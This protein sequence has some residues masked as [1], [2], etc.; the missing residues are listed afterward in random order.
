MSAQLTCDPIVKI[1]LT[2]NEVFDE[3]APGYVLDC[4]V[5]TK[6]L[7]KP[8][9]FEF[10]IRK[11]ELTLE[12]SD[13][14]FELRDKLLAAM[15]EVTLKA[16]YHDMEEDDFK[17]YEVEDF[18]YGYI[19]NIKVLRSNGSPV[20][21]KCV[22]YSP[23]A[24]MKHHPSSIS[25]IDTKLEA[26]VNYVLSI[27]A[28]EKMTHF[29]RKEG[30]YSEPN[31]YL[32]SILEPQ[33]QGE[34]MPYT[35][36]FRE[37]PYNFL[38]RLARR[39]AEFMYYE[40]RKF[41]F[42]KMQELPE[43]VLHNGADLEE[44]T[45]EMNMNDHDGP[46]Y[47]SMDTYNRK[48]I[49]G[50]YQKKNSPDS[51]FSIYEGV[52]FGDGYD[53]MA[54]STY[55]AAS[56]YF[57]DLWTSADELG[58][59][60]LHDKDRKSIGDDHELKNW[61]SRQHEY[62]ERY[63]MS[64]A[65]TCT[66]K[67]A[68]VD[69]KLGSVIK[70]K[71]Q[72]KIDEKEGEWKEHTPL[73]VVELMYYWNSK[74]NLAV[75][76]RFKA[77]PQSA[78]VPPYLERDKDG[79]LVYG[80]FDQYPKSGPQYGVVVDNEDPDHLGRVR[81]ALAWQ[82]L[83]SGLVCN[84]TKTDELFTNK[85]NVTP[86]IWVVSPYQGF[87]HGALAIPEI[88]SQV[89]VGF[90]QNNAE[91]PYVMGSRYFKDTMKPEWTK[92]DQNKV[93]GFRTRSGHTVEF[94][95]ADGNN[96]FNAFNNGGRI[97]IYDAETHAYDILFDT[98][99]KLIRMKSKGNI[100]LYA[101]KDIVMQAGNDIVIT[102]ENDMTEHIGNNLRIDAEK[103]ISQNAGANFNTHSAENTLISADKEIGTVSSEGTYID[104][105]GEFK[106]VVDE[107]LSMFAEKDM[108]LSDSNNIDISAEKTLEIKGKDIVGNAKNEFSEYSSDHNIKAQNGVKI[109]AT[110]SIDLK[111]LTI[112]E[113]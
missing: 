67:S 92:Y 104:V 14:D 88:G 111:A 82:L 86:W 56:D 78:T 13:I 69:L 54:K 38:V 1:T 6:G 41:I 107:E 24:R 62:L 23:D 87:D 55:N 4:F 61:Y 36:Q 15:V 76:N 19:Q 34:I 91:R 109:N 40:N 49:G 2:S 83:H 73:K 108:H 30:T 77:I 44:F 64:D 75:L 48:L 12:P 99:Q 51:S 18:F 93:K 103:D 106:L 98:D 57:G 39:Y 85:D 97:H 101:D 59:T 81:V 112:K 16:R 105:Y 65:L 102:A 31:N 66:G 20:T 95:D 71:D 94:I 10:V 42:G 74:N 5:L 50:C 32:E 84:S 47:I 68:R 29:N 26:A 28:M 9:K 17:E 7:L 60:P 100:E 8:N 79:F 113:N 11:E 37:S 22:A 63:V 3:I 53:A 70:I 27:N 72:T 21:F 33:H 52:D 89:L 110:S 25:F 90:E 46:F 58:A 35:V 43:I 80:D 45:Y 96:A